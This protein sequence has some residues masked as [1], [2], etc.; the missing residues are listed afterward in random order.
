MPLFTENERR[1]RQQAV[2]FHQN[3]LRLEG[4]EVPEAIRAL[5]SR[6]VEGEL[7]DNAFRAACLEFA[8][9]IAK[10]PHWRPGLATAPQRP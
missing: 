2:A 10:N 4:I 6:Y 9:S 1:R 5:Q 7:D 8:M 3:N